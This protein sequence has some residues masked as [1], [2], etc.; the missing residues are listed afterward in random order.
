MER[1][2]RG[3]PYCEKIKPGRTIINKQTIRI[4]AGIY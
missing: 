1:V 2:R 4:L 3:R